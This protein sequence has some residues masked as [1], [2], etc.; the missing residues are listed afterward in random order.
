MSPFYNV[1]LSQDRPGYSL[2]LTADHSI[3][4]HGVILVGSRD[5]TIHLLLV[6]GEPPQSQRFRDQRRM[7]VSTGFKGKKSSD[8]QSGL[9]NRQG[10]NKQSLDHLCVY[11]E[12]NF[13]V[14]PVIELL[15]HG[16]DGH[17]RSKCSIY[18]KTIT[19]N[20]LLHLHTQAHKHTRT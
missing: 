18:S 12:C 5:T 14:A 6:I 2:H 19:D 3:M 7:C 9:E 1:S 11:E 16:V 20:F 10:A 8:G 17:S 15:V 13:H 4:R